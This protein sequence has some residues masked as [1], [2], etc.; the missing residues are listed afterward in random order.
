M[1]A[2]LNPAGIAGQTRVNIAALRALA[3]RRRKASLVAQEVG[4]RV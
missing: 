2:M 3:A 1:V 4:S